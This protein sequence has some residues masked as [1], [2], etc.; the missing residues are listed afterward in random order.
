MEVLTQ[1]QTPYLGQGFYIG[2]ADVCRKG[3]MAGG[4]WQRAVQGAV[5]DQSWN[6]G[7]SLGEERKT[8]QAKARRLAQRLNKH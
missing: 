6:A 2:S 8:A 4:V 5:L 1:D 7:R 3:Q